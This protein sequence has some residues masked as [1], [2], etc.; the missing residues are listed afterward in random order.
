MEY[1]TIV[2]NNNLYVHVSIFFLVLNFSMKNFFLI[3]LFVKDLLLQCFHIYN[4]SYLN[5]FQYFKNLIDGFNKMKVWH[6]WWYHPKDVF[7][8]IFCTHKKLLYEHTHIE[9]IHKPTHKKHNE[10][11]KKITWWSYMWFNRM[12]LHHYYQSCLLCPTFLFLSPCFYNT[13]III[14]FHSFLT[15][16]LIKYLVI[17]LEQ[18]IIFILS[19]S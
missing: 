2:K 11:Q 7:A 15:F 10:L 18:Y 3:I 12:R 6:F 14:F 8:P 19:K 17:P 9:H 5:V 4:Q 13:F 1:F 16:F